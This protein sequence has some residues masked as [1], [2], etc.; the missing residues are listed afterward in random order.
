MLYCGTENN[1]TLALVTVM[2]LDEKCYE[3]RTKHYVLDYARKKQQDIVQNSSSEIISGANFPKV[4][5][6]VFLVYVVP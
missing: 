6:I 1:L 5:F 4:T 3:D 2:K